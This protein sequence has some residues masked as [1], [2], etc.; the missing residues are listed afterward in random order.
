[1]EGASNNLPHMTPVT[2]Q[3]DDEGRRSGLALVVVEPYLNIVEG[4][5]SEPIYETPPRGR[6]RRVLQRMGILE[7][8]AEVLHNDDGTADPLAGPEDGAHGEEH[9]QP[10]RG[11][12]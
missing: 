1:M 8:L 10:Y 2:L 12:R 6:R 4:F 5:V 7:A 9:C 11:G 3:R